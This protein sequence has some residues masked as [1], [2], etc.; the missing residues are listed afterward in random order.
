MSQENLNATDKEL[1]MGL[2]RQLYENRKLI[3]QMGKN[4][5][6]NKYAST[7][8][9]AVWGFIQPLVFMFM[10]MFVFQFILKQGTSG[11]YPYVV[12]FLPGIAMWMF[13]NDAVINGCTSIRSYS[14]LVKKIVFPIGTIPFIT[15]TSSMIVSSI[16]MG[17]S[18]FICLLFGFVPNLLLLLYYYVAALFLIIAL[19]RVTAAVCTMLPDFVKVVEILMQLLFWFTP[20]I[21]NMDMLS[22]SNL[23]VIAMVNPVAYIVTGFR[24]AFVGGNT[25][26]A[27]YGLHTYV[28]WG[29]VVFFFLYGEYIFNKS[30][31]QYADVL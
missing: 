1:S 26:G 28:F 7:S 4:D 10:Y 27:Y 13:F 12:W 2:F 18:I 19:T 6:K 16:V 3:F 5:F 29:L 23:G 25:I 8:L 21:W 24:E 22:G 11:N 17:I 31:N 15:L 20:I 14:Y 9:G 30:K